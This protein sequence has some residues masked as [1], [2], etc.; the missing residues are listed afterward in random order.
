MMKKDKIFLITTILVIGT[1]AISAPKV[2]NLEPLN[3]NDLNSSSTQSS[4]D[5]KTNSK[6]DTKTMYYPNANIKS[7]IDKYTKGNYTGCLQELF[8]LVQKQPNN[9]SAYYYMALAY[10]NIGMQSEAVEAYEK[11]IELKPDSYIAEYATKGKDCLTGGPTCKDSD[12]EDGKNKEE[13]QDDL[14]KFINAPYGNGLSPA[15]NKELKEK[16]LSN[17]KDTINDKKDLERDDIQRIR[18]FDKGTD[19]E[20]YD[21][22][23]YEGETY[24]VAQVSDEEV[25]NAI[26]TLKDA[27]VNVTISNNPYMNT[28]QDPQMAELSMMLGNNNGYNNNNSM[29]NMLPMLMAQNKEGK[30]IDPRVMQA[31]MMNTMMSDFT[32]N[33]NNDNN[34]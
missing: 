24:K 23:S 21:N 30:N 26:K 15:L 16:E 1:A 13:G 10:S 32:F 25:L 18:K 31:M 11:V 9:A 7:A 4:K 33:T 20:N 8:S 14:D 17:I 27:G 5:T 29:M 19:F 3:L 34:R 22:E 6:L 28:Y 12:S 2:N